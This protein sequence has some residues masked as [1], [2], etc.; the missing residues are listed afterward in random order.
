M[1]RPHPGQ[2]DIHLTTTPRNLG[3][4]ETQWVVQTWLGCP[5]KAILNYNLA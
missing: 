1:P 2:G 4:E 5:S 3:W